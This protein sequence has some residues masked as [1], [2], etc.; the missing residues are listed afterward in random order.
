MS[1]E[2]VPLQ[3]KT[4]ARSKKKIISQQ[5][6]KSQTREKLH[7]LAYIGY[8][9]EPCEIQNIECEAGHVS[10]FNVGTPYSRISCLQFQI[11]FNRLGKFSFSLFQLLLPFRRSQERIVRIVQEEDIR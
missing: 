6:D 5:H 10:R 7:F 4:R 1:C 2:R 9:F 3:K 11:L 8:Q